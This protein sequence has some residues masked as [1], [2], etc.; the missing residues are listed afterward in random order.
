MLGKAWHYAVAALG[1]AGAEQL[2]HILTADL[3]ANMAQLGI[4]R[5]KD[6]RER[7]VP[8]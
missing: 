4:T 7:L 8:A 5:L 1:A 3:K 6:V 2:V